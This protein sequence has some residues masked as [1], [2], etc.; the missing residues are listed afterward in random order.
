MPSLKSIQLG[1]TSFAKYSRFVLESGSSH[2]QLCLDL[3]EL[4][5]VHLGRE[6]CAFD[7]DDTE[8]ELIMRSRESYLI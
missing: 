8:S 2:S 3:P 6:G 1:V 7:E 5:S 4:E